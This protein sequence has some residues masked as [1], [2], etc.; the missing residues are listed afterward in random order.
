MCATHTP[1][2][3]VCLSCVLESHP[4][5]H[6]QKGMRDE[7]EADPSHLILTA[8]SIKWDSYTKKMK[9]WA[10]PDHSLP[11]ILTH[12]SLS[13][14]R[15]LYVI[16]LSAVAFS[17]PSA[18]LQLPSSCTPVALQLPSSCPPAALQLPSSFPSAALQLNTGLK[19][20][21]CEEIM[22]F[23]W[24]CITHMQIFRALNIISSLRT[25]FMHTCTF[26]YVVPS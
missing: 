20:H 12:S 11:V 25:T 6:F 4:P 1:V 2:C 18:A 15:V 14:Y 23:A 19:G 17:C 9:K 24:N 7:H 13:S 16:L 22:S 21:F 26:Y 8:W 5:Q 3:V 10:S